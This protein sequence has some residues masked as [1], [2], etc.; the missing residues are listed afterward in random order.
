MTSE[1]EKQYN[2]AF[3]LGGK[4]VNLTP[5]PHEPKAMPVLQLSEATA[6]EIEAYNAEYRTSAV[7]PEKAQY[8]ESEGTAAAYATYNA[9][10][11]SGVRLPQRILDELAQL[12]NQLE[13]QQKVIDSLIEE[14]GRFSES[15]LSERKSV[16]KDMLRAYAQET[17]LPQRDAAIQ[18]M[19]AQ[20]EIGAA[21]R[22][23]I[24]ARKE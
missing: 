22:Q 8:G 13:D 15:Q 14:P 9:E 1:A 12:T 4:R 5:A 20:D 6:A 23:L 3:K 11:G 21:F 24:T 19:Q 10:H 7:S 16:L 2:E 17:G 18:L